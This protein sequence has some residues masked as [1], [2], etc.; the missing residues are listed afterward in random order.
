ME[1]CMCKTSILGYELT[2]VQSQL[3]C[4]NRMLSGCKVSRY[5]P[6]SYYVLIILTMSDN[7]VQT[8][9]CGASRIM[10]NTCVHTYAI[11]KLYTGAQICQ[12]HPTHTHIIHTCI[13]N[14]YDY[15]LNECVWASTYI[16]TCISTPVRVCAYKY[17]YEDICVA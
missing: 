9:N 12:V 1:L 16:Y 4:H 6:G 11:S 5:P 17:S 3:S 13:S 14:L 15:I 7:H 8:C 10:W 2:C